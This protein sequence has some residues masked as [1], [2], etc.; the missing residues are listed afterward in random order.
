MK[1]NYCIKCGEET[2][3]GNAC[4]HCG[5]A[6]VTSQCNNCKNYYSETIAVVSEWLCLKCCASVAELTTQIASDATINLRD[7]EINY[8]G[9]I[10]IWEEEVTSKNLLLEENAELRKMIGGEPYMKSNKLTEQ[11]ILQIRKLYYTMSAARI[12][13]KFKVVPSAIFYQIDKAEKLGLEDYA[14]IKKQRLHNKS[15]DDISVEIPK[16]V[17]VMP[18]VKKVLSLE[19]IQE[20]TTISLRAKEDIQRVLQVAAQQILEITGAS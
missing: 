1:T 17:A 20:I 13:R 15:L 8:A 16:V 6:T 2:K 11:Q 7:A 5:Y 3:V 4:E 9:L 18:E 14:N 12:A 10:K 19:D